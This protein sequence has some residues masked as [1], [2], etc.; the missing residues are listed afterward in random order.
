MCWGV[1]GITRVLCDNPLRVTATLGQCSKIHHFALWPAMV[2]VAC[3][4]VGCGVWKTSEPIFDL[5]QLLDIAKHDP[6]VS[7]K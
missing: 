4:A 5:D 6:F 3:M 2:V 7:A 1:L